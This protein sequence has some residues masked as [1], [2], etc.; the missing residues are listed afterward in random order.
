[1]TDPRWVT[2]S[3]V[4]RIHGE[5]LALFG[6]PAGIRDEG[7]LQSALDRPRN[8]FSYG[9]QNLGVLAA[10]YAYG[11]SKNHPFVDGNK[12]VSFAVLMVFLRKNG[13]AFRPDQSAATKIMYELAAG[14]VDEEAVA[15]WI[16][17][18][19][20]QSPSTLGL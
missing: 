14:A 1:M 18:T 6:G 13:L 11:L 2:L 15:V 8:K 10:A 16:Q 9:E 7:A 17:R 12:R 3:Q 20:E 19:L 4:V 5:Q